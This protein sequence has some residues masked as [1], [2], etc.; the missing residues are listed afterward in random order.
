MADNEVTSL[1]KLSKSDFIQMI[2]EFSSCID[3]QN[4]MV[5]NQREEIELRNQAFKDIQDESNK[6]AKK[7]TRLGS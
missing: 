6:W 1:S 7:A 4:E 5:E 2:K 3:A